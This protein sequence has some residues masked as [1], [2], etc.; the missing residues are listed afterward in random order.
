MHICEND[1]LNKAEIKMYGRTGRISRTVVL[2]TACFVLGVIE[3]VCQFD[4]S[5][6]THTDDHL[7]SL[8]ISISSVSDIPLLHTYYLPHNSS[9]FTLHIYEYL[10]NPQH[11]QLP[12]FAFSAFLR[13]HGKADP[14]VKELTGPFLAKRMAG[15]IKT[16]K[17]K[18][19]VA[20]RTFVRL[21]I[22]RIDKYV[23]TPCLQHFSNCIYTSSITSSKRIPKKE[24]TC[25]Q[26][27]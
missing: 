7:W 11:Q 4:A 8:V 12:K 23:H 1:N 18:D 25:A 3:K 16:N 15:T 14:G 19:F 5:Y 22:L 26:R 6:S 2:L 24:S 9:W 27:K 17:F 20:G 21:L 13:W 10:W